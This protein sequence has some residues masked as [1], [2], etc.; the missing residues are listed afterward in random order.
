MTSLAPSEI[1]TTAFAA[2]AFAATAFAATAF[3]VVALAASA[4]GLTAL[5]RVLAALPDDF[6]AAVL[7]VQHL[8]PDR[9]SYLAAILG[10]QTP[11]RVKEAEA[12]ET[13]APGVAF[14][15]P[16][17]HHLLVTAG[18]QV[19]LSRTA[20][21]HFVRPSANRL[22]ESVA[23]HYGR[24]AIA[25]VLSGTGADGSEGARAVHERGGIVI[26]QERQSAEY[27]GMP[28]AAV[29]TGAVDF[30]LPLEAI[31]AALCELARTGHMK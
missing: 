16:P 7:V 14:V 31:A 4:G 6:P 22:F 19:E 13:L 25:V 5:G 1:V 9:H 29:R 21:V 15:A 12:A 3:D 28:D 10:R 11:L 23:T 24:R 2:T 30:V 8:A 18:G 17:D 27:S 20:A 26:A